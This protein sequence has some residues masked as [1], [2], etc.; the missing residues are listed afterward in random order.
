M[1]NIREII[2]HNIVSLRKQHGMTQL[3]LAQKVNY[4]DKAVSRWEK[5]EVMP[6]VETLQSISEAFNV[7]LAY[8][9]EEHQKVSDSI[10]ESERN[11]LLVKILMVLAVWT[12]ATIVFVYGKINYNIIYWLIYVWAVP[13]SCA[14]LLYLNKKPK[15]RLVSLIC[16]SILCWSLLA[17]IYLQF[18]E[19]QSWI[20]F[21]IGIP[22]QAAIIVSYLAKKIRK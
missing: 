3:D 14:V 15:N 2:S 12:L 9:F 4:S 13:A 1:K 7:P 22:L 5:G 8:L 17:C 19:Y 10:V 11:E 18:M 20:V 16:S 6:D 21:L